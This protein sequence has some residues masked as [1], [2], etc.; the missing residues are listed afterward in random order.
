MSKEWINIHKPLFGAFLETKLQPSNARRI[1]KAVPRGWKHFGNFGSHN[2]ARIVVVWDPRVSVVVYKES[3]Q[4]ITC[5]FFLRSEN[6]N[7]TVSF[8]YGFNLVEERVTLWEELAHLHSS[9]PLSRSPW[10]VIGDFNQILRSEHNSQ[11]PAANIDLHGV[12]DFEL[13]LQD[14]NLFE[15][16]SKGL[17]FTW[18][19]HREEDPTSKRIDH[20]L[21]DEYWARSFPDAYSEFLE[22]GQSDHAPCLFSIPNLQRVVK[23]PFKFYCHVVDHPDFTETIDSEW[24]ASIISGSYQ[25]KLARSLKLLKPCLRRLNRDH[26][27]G[28][29]ARVKEKAEEVA[30]IHRQIL[31]SPTISLVSEEI[32]AS[33]EWNKLMIA[34]EKFYMQKSR[35]QWMHLGDRNIEFFHKMV[36]QRNSHNHI[37]FLTD[38]DGNKITFTEDLHRH[39]VDYFRSVFGAT[40]LPSSHVT[41]EYLQDLLPFRCSSAQAVSLLQ[42]VSGE[43]I[44]DIVFAMPSNKSP[45][46]DGYPA[47]FFKSVWSSVGPELTLAVQEFFRNGRLLKDLN[48]TIIALIP[49]T[50]EASSLNIVPLAAA[51]WHTKLSLRFWPIA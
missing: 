14:S 8:V 34:E 43:E 3:A 46:P 32:I 24:S 21:I 35:I 1:L 4:V 38:V 15:A 37:H 13:A 10:A 50:P 12:S 51:I 2:T 17:P 7:F 28:I 16:P 20:A 48:A 42:H 36:I 5:G 19:N 49:K 45:G 44:R 33:D 18:W 23:R 40:D 29:T 6:I 26:F 47:E 11:F 41:I 27:S 31:S 25:F 30:V 22:P 39:A 9:T